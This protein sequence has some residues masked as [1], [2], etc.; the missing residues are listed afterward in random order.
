ML[1][2]N[3]SAYSFVAVVLFNLVFAQVDFVLNGGLVDRL[4]D[5]L[6]YLLFTTTCCGHSDALHLSGR[7]FRQH[8][9]T[10]SYMNEMWLGLKKKAQMDYNKKVNLLNV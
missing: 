3:Q 6:G 10:S 7:A 4:M 8:N 1:M 5:F 9:N 2:I